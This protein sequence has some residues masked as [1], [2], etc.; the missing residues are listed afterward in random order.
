MKLSKQNLGSFP[1]RDYEGF[2]LEQGTGADLKEYPVRT[3]LPCMTS[4]ER[5]KL[6]GALLVQGRE[7]QWALHSLSISPTLQVPA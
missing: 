1:P 6:E 3:L 7:G 4:T 2:H 5:T